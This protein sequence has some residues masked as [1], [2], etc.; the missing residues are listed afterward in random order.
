MPFFCWSHMIYNSKPLH[1]CSQ[2]NSMPLQSSN[3]TLNF[4][5]ESWKLQEIRKLSYYDKVVHLCN[6]QHAVCKVLN[7]RVFSHFIWKAS[8]ANLILSLPL[9]PCHSIG[10]PHLWPD[11]SCFI[12]HHQVNIVLLEAHSNST[13]FNR[14]S[15]YV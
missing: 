8:S 4:A 15:N 14:N 7:Y 10:F 5:V 11:H 13:H 1:W 6:R 9:F 12:Y 2:V 3:F